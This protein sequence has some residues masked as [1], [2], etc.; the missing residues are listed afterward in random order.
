[1][2]RLFRMRRYNPKSINDKYDFLFPQ[3]ITTNILRN[4]NG[5]VLE[6][7]LL[8]YDRHLE[9]S[10]LHLNRALS[11]GSARALPTRMATRFGIIIM[12]VWKPSF[13]PSTN[14]S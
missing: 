9:D 4:E 3:A 13:A 14:A 11:S 1:M 10:I 8:Q 7:D 2:Y 6:S 5:G 12:A